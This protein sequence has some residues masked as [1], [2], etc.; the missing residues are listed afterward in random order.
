MDFKQRRWGLL[1]ILV[2]LF[3]VTM[4][5]SGVKTTYADVGT[6]PV[7]TSTSSPFMTFSVIQY[8]VGPLS[9]VSGAYTY[10]VTDG[11]KLDI[12]AS[13]TLASNETGWSFSINGQPVTPVI[14]D[15]GG[16]Y[17]AAWDDVIYISSTTEGF[18]KLQWV[19]PGGGGEWV[20]IYIGDIPA[21]TQA[22]VQTNVASNITAN[23]AILNGYISSDGGAT[24]TD[25]GFNQTGSVGSGGT[26]AFSSVW[27]G[28]SPNQ[29]YSYQAYATNAAGTA[30]GGTNSFWTMAATPGLTSAALQP[31]RSVVLT[32]NKNGNPTNTN[33]MVQMATDANFTQNVATVV[34]WTSPGAGT[35]LAVPSSKMNPGTTY[36]F[37]LQAE[38]GASVAS[39]YGAQTVSAS[40][41]P[42]IALTP[43][44]ASFNA[45]ADGSMPASQT[46]VFT[47]ANGTFS[48]TTGQT[49]AGVSVNNLPAGLTAMATLDSTTQMTLSFS[50][51]ATNHSNANNVPNVSVGVPQV[52]VV[53]A[54]ATVTSGSFA[55]D[56]LLPPSATLSITSPAT[57]ALDEGQ[58]KSNAAL[59]SLTMTLGNETW[60]STS[61]VPAGFTLNN[62]PPGLSIAGVT[63]VDPTHATLTL[64]DNG[65]NFDTPYNN[66]SVTISSSQLPSSYALTSNTLPVTCETKPVVSTNTPATKVA[67]TEYTSGGNVTSDGGYP[68]TA[69]GVVYSTQQNP[70][71]GSGS[72]TEVDAGSGTGSFTADLTGLS[73]GNTYFVRAFAT[74]AEG[75]AYGGQDSIITPANNAILAELALSNG[76]LTP[77]FS[78]SSTAYAASVANSVSSITV[79]PTLADSTASLTVNGKTAANGQASAAIPLN[80]GVNTI[81]ITVTAADGTTQKTYTVTVTR[82][83]SA[84]ANLSSLGISPGSLSPALSENV[85]DYTVTVPDSTSSVQVT[86]SAEDANATI[87]VNGTQLT[88]GNKL[89]VSIASNNL[90][91][92]VVTAQDGTPKT[93]SV[94]VLKSNYLSFKYPDFA[95]NTNLLQINRNAALIN[96][97]TLELTPNKTNQAGS[98]FYKKEYSLV[99]DRSFSTY[100]SFKLSGRGGIGQADGI[101]FA[102]QTVSN[103]AGSL[104]GGLGF[105]GLNPAVGVEFDTWHNGE[106]NDPTAPHI[107]LD[108]NG[109]VKSAAT[110]LTPWDIRDGNVYYAWIDYNGPDKT[111]EVRLNTTPTRPASPVLTYNKLDL[112]SILNQSEVYV[113][114]TGATG[115]AS[116]EQD[117]LSWYFNNDDTHIDTQTYS[118]TQTPTTVTTTLNPTDNASQTTVQAT[119]LNL[120]G[121]AATN[122]P[123]TF[124]TTLGSFTTS[125]T[126]SSIS[127]LT[128]ASGQASATLYAAQSSGAATV[129]AVAE[130]G[131]WGS[132]T[133]NNLDLTDPEAVAA[134]KANLAIGYAP[135]DS[136]SSVT[137]NLTLP[138]TGANGTAI[139]WG[140]SDTS[141][142]NPSGTTGSVTRPGYFNG[143]DQVTLTAT[144][145]KGSAT[146]T[147]TFTVNV[148]AQPYVA[149][150]V[151]ATP[152]VGGIKETAAND[153]SVSGTINVS[154]SG[155]TFASDI[156]AADIVVNDLPSGLTPTVTYNT[157]T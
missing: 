6:G 16:L 46:E 89:S 110:A 86:A 85:T 90:I 29:N 108:I 55:I 121:T 62:P 123:L 153:G 25:R 9:P 50:G 17:T 71:I 36:Y 141:V 88:S 76:L 19:P 132:Q 131:A 81:T 58:L 75:T 18:Y 137:Q 149:P 35:T 42:P 152:S 84:D 124:S 91:S 104:G 61:L 41:L 126:I 125:G 118:Y 54:S 47:L 96:G 140:S 83:G 40:Q 102:L 43:G 145:S 142:I 69:R 112:E 98:V 92:V 53:G 1:I 127:V 20:N 51:T 79:T 136:V 37:R 77:A 59:Y 78:T 38:N 73:P 135:G 111:I 154:I 70:S 146:D 56:F 28:L 107:G 39:G 7:G 94:R 116:Q 150:V 155:G 21:Y 57:T 93:Y 52:D 26:G 68:V 122:I 100:F 2:I 138:A 120:D 82:K 72:A 44:I 130:G 33:Y 99:N 80:V 119:A 139:V 106:N 23:S 8:G 27:S 87:K 5:A 144:I 31:D 24:V 32:L 133:I 3:Q 66:L 65:T 67:A 151:T 129:K 15:N 74:N 34:S 147:Q 105:A 12:H 114:F 48:G 156:A 113:G 45:N 60:A 4:L 10:A 22:T 134:D 14:S 143:D 49:L 128:N 115:G 101:V 11:T 64:A 95:S 97:N 13:L 30:Y 148:K 109:S 157:N 103:T 117:I 63:Y